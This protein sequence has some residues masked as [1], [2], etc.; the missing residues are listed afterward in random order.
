MYT[1]TD[2][3]SLGEIDWDVMKA[4]YWADTDDDPDRKRRR[5]AE[6]LVYRKFPWDRTEMIAVMNIKIK[7]QVEGIIPNGAKKHPIR[8][9]SDWYF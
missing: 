5:Q 1:L 3:E 7:K 2:L 4:V 6:F 8:V 9:K